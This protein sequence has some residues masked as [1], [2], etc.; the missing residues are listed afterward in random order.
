MSVTGTQKLRGVVAELWNGT[1]KIAKLQE[2]TLD[3]SMSTVDVTDHDSGGWGEKMTTFAQWTATA[4]AWLWV[5]SHGV[6]DDSQSAIFDALP[7][8]TVLSVEFRPLGTLS[9]N[10]KWSGSCRVSKVSTNSPTSG[11][12]GFDYSLEGIGALVRGT[13]T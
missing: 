6:L 12:Q 1:T 11:A 8:A 10:S 5:D 3:V 9:G 2:Y 4:K 7:A 13:Q